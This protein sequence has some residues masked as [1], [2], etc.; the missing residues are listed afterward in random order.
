MADAN[1][2]IAGLAQQIAQLTVDK[3]IL[4]AELTETQER[5]VKLEAPEGADYMGEV[6]DIA[7]DAA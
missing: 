2:I 4:T 3:A 1:T 6:A 5:L 7:E